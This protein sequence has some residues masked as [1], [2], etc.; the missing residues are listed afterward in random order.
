MSV[1]LLIGEVNTECGPS[2]TEVTSGT[3]EKGR[4]V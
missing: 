4:W 3:E 1:R 2:V